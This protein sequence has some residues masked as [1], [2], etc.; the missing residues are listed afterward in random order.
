MGLVF[1][2][3]VKI[4]FEGLD[5]FLKSLN[6]KKLSKQL[7]IGIAHA[8]QKLEGDIRAAVVNTYSVSS[9]DVGKVLLGKARSTQK[10]GKNLI[11][12]GIE[13]KYKP[14]P[15]NEFPFKEFA[16]SARSRFALPRAGKGL[17]FIKQNKAKGVKV[18]VKRGRY[19][20]VVGNKGFGG[21]HKSRSSTSKWAAI[22]GGRSSS[23][24]A[25][26]YIREQEA[27]W[28]TEPID[29][30]PIRRLYGP[31]LVQM[32]DSVL[33]NDPL[34]SDTFENFDLLVSKFI[35]L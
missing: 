33:D 12:N 27:T 18:A 22:Q 15:L 35:T 28:I 29:R 5:N 9:S 1:M 21:F 31:S 32:I 3:N 19:K 11:Q 25:G 10:R 17:A 23:R 4:E 2:E 20:T 13:Y 34:V 7:E 6:T 16:V 30:A 26:I 24:P 14:K 8:S